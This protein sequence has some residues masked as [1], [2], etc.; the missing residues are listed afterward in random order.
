HRSV[1]W[2]RGLGARQCG[3]P[4]GIGAEHQA[5]RQAASTQLGARPAPLPRW[6]G[7]GVHRDPRRVHRLDSYVHFG[8]VDVLVPLASSSH[9]VA[10]AWGIV[11]LYLV[12]AVEV[13]SLLRK[14]LSKRLWR[15]THF[16]SFPLFALATTHALSAGTDRAAILM[17]YGAAL[18]TISVVL[19][20]AVRVVGAR[21]RKPVDLGGMTRPLRYEPPRRALNAPRWSTRFP[22]PSLRRTA[23]PRSREAQGRGSS[24][25]SGTAR[26]IPGRWSRSGGARRVGPCPWPIPPR[27]PRSPR[28]G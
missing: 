13:T 14:Q 7:G 16:A 19:L 27:V 5:A 4:V 9:P 21:R 20:T 11:A 17:R 23:F 1:E 10:V 8:L 15:A 24:S 6:G 2:H 3:R 18:T 28:Y 12:L 25:L 26:R 22:S